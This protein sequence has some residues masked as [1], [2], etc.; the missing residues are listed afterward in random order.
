MAAYF[1]LHQPRGRTRDHSLSLYETDGTTVVTL[2]VT[3]VVRVKI[4]NGNN[5]TPDL[6]L[7]DSATAGGSVVTVDSLTTAPQCTLRIAQAD[8]ANLPL[9]VY[10]VDIDVVDDSETA[11]ANAIKHAQSGLL[12]LTGTG[13]GDVGLT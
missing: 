4:G 6:D 1:E 13:G 8:T 12:Y 2:A 9:G 3:D 5:V 7:D 11:P 10:A